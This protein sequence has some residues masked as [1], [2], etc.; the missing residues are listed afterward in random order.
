VRALGFGAS[1]S[2]S[3]LDDNSDSSDISS[4]LGIRR[5]TFGLSSGPVRLGGETVHLRLGLV[6]LVS[7]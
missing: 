2:S 5:R 4:K 3:P 6:F 7:S 1:S